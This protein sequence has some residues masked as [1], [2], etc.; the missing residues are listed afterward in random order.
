RCIFKTDT[1]L[2]DEQMTMIGFANGSTAYHNL[3]SGAAQ[4]GRRIK[5]YG[6]KGEID[7]FTEDGYFTVRLYNSENILFNERRETIS[8]DIAGDNHYGGDARIMRDF[9][10]LERGEKASVSTSSLK[11]SVI[12]HLCVYAADVSMAENRIVK[13]QR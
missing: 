4:A 5:I 12:S 7:G 3:Y 6:T 10:A 11:S 2:V 8:E 1:D 9:L 13:I